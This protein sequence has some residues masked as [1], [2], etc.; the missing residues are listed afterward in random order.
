MTKTI[1]SSIAVFLFACAAMAAD[2]T[3]DRY[4]EKDPLTPSPGNTTYFVDSVKD[5]GVTATYDRD[6]CKLLEL[7]HGAQ[8]LTVKQPLFALETAK[9]EFINSSAFRMQK[10]VH[11]ESTNFV[12]EPSGL[13]KTRGIICL[14]NPAGADKA[15]T[16]SM[17]EV[18]ELAP[19]AWKLSEVVFSADSS[20][21]QT[22]I[23][24]G[25]LH[26]ALP[27]YKVVVIENQ[28]K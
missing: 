2:S 7:V 17:T 3:H 26:V 27:G 5:A 10:S 25:T 11:A 1:H 21:T 18:M 13:I 28:R 20:G 8:K 16:F 14:R 22:R 19:A 6:H 9:G 12:H 23:D 15:Q 24:G 4:L